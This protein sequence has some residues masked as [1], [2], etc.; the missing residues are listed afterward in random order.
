MHIYKTYIY[1]YIC[2]DMY[3]SYKQNNFSADFTSGYLYVIS[4]FYKIE[5]INFFLCKEEL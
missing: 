4:L 2:I 5:N 1:I 3:F